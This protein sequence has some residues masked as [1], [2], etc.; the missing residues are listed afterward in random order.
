MPTKLILND[1]LT[2][3]EEVIANTTATVDPASMA[4]VTGHLTSGIS[5]PGAAFGDHVIVTAPYDLQGVIA[6]GQVSAADTVKI[7][8]FNPTGGTIDLAS[9]TYNILV[10]RF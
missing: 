10:L 4:T 7:S 1:G 2:L 3:F 9:G 8:F 5:V 6:N